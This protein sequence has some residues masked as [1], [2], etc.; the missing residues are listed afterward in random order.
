MQPIPIIPVYADTIV[1][2]WLFLVE[3]GQ[4]RDNR[5]YGPLPYYGTHG[6]PVSVVASKALGL[7]ARSRCHNPPSSLPAGTDSGSRDA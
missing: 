6:A 1:R 4:G 3:V 2:H 7:E 5:Q